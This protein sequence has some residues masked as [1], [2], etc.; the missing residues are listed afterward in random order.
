MKRV[1]EILII[2]T[3]VG[4][5]PSLILFLIYKYNLIIILLS[6]ISLKNI[7]KGVIKGE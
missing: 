1:V 5:I 6:I 2:L 7:I 4:I 3:I